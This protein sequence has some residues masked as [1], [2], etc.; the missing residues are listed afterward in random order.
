MGILSNLNENR[1]KLLI[2]PAV[3]VGVLIFVF[4]VQ[5]K[6]GPQKVPIQERTI[7]VR[8]IEVPSVELLPRV[9]AFGSVQPGMVWEGVAQ[10]AGT[11]VHQHPQLKKGARLN[12]GEV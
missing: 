8:T 11:I 7:H 3:L 5:S 4:L 6:R 9:L 10:V 12:Q 1:K 2:I